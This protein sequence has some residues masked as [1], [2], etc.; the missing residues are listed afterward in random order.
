MKSFSKWASATVAIVVLAGA[1]RADNFSVASGTVKSINADK[2]EFML[3]DAATGKDETIKFGDPLVINRG[4]KDT[5][6]DLKVG[7]LVDV[8]HEKG[9]VTWPAHYILV[10][11][12]ATKNSSLVRG[13]VKG[14]DADKK[15]LTFTDEHGKDW[16][17]PMSD[18]KVTLNNKEGKIKDVKI[19]D[20]GLAI[21]EKTGDKMS[22]KLLMAEQK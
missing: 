16:N 8:C 11:E 22:L 7:D 21:V 1:A 9:F 5:A 6:S 20:N 19:G 10:K 3:T 18:A 14:Y 13:S 15:E 17:F 12:G 2:K 4:G